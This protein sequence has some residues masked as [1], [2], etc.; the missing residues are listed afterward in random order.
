L[1]RTR[2]AAQRLSTVLLLFA[3][4][5]F[6]AEAAAFTETVIKAPVSQAFWKVSI[7]VTVLRPDGAGP[8][9]LVV[10]N[11]GSP[12]SAQERRK[13]GRQRFVKQAE[14]FLAMGYAVIVPT[15]RG[16]GESGGEWA[17]GY[18]SCNDPDYYSAGLETAKDVLAALE[19]V[20]GE[21]WAD[22]KRVVLAGHSA[23]GF[24]SVAAASRPFDGLVGVINFAGGRGSMAPQQVCEEA[25]LVDA[26]GR[27]GAGAKTPSLWVYSA[28]DQF[29]GPQ[30]AQRMHR[31]YVRSGGKAEFVEAPP[32][33]AD[34]H[35]YFARSVDDWAPRVRDFLQRI[36]AAR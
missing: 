22:T 24:G 15:R 35:S 17:E 25:R 23:G 30:L 34:G 6:A 5:A 21:P 26:M 28:N 14:P 13:W 32:A 7:E 2:S 3:A 1:E 16:Y 36:G 19:A 27:Y 11:H 33:G 4:V 9:P 31:A 29:F 12:R 10:L 18:G 8:F 20:R